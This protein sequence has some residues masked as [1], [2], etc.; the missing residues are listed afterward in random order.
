M[1]TMQEKDQVGTQ[2]ACKIIKRVN[3]DPNMFYQVDIIHSKP[4]LS[5]NFSKN[6]QANTKRNENQLEEPT[7]CFVI[8]Q[9]EN[10]VTNLAF[11]YTEVKLVIRETLQNNF[12]TAIFIMAHIPIRILAIICYHK[13]LDD[14]TYLSLSIFLMPFRIILTMVHAVL[15]YRKVT[16]NA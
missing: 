1:S 6:G 7:T 9:Q 3:G 2:K 8:P 16:K 11:D 13:P 15:T 5:R 10:P 12:I 14:V 4:F